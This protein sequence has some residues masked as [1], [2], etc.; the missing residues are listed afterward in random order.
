MILKCIGL[1]FPP[2][3]FYHLR[4]FHKGLLVPSG[5]IN[6]QGKADRISALLCNNVIMPPLPREWDNMPPTGHIMP[7]TGG[8]IRPRATLCCPQFA[9][10]RPRAA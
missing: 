4:A 5:M 10:C 1:Q 9:L 2:K 7:P 3:F 6:M 8:I